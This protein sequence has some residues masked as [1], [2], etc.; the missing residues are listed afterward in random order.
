M[1][2]WLTGWETTLD[3]ILDLPEVVW[4]PIELLEYINNERPFDWEKDA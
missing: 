3:Q 4:I 2:I 1:S